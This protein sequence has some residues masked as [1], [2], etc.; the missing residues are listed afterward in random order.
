MQF[1]PLA[2][3]VA[4]WRVNACP[5]L[6]AFAQRRGARLCTGQCNI[7]STAAPCTPAVSRECRLRDVIEAIGP[8]LERGSDN[9]MFVHIDAAQEDQVEAQYWPRTF[10]EGVCL[11]YSF[12]DH[13]EHLWSRRKY[14]QV[15][16]VRKSVLAIAP[17]SVPCGKKRDLRTLV[18]YMKPRP[19]EHERDLFGAYL[20][21]ALMCRHN[22]EFSEDRAAS[23]VTQWTGYKP[24]GLVDFWDLRPTANVCVRWVNEGNTTWNAVS[25][26]DE[27]P[28]P[29]HEVTAYKE[30]IERAMRTRENPGGYDALSAVVLNPKTCL[31]DIEGF[32]DFVDPLGADTESGVSGDTPVAARSDAK[33]QLDD[34]GE[35]CRLAHECGRVWTRLNPFRRTRNLSVQKRGSDLRGHFVAV[36]TSDN[37]AHETT[38]DP[39]L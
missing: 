32:E 12:M 8:Q 14:W 16:R 31:R 23:L 38:R 3:N 22:R 1:E 18:M 5:F 4:R 36:P 19:T 17:V 7:M 26:Y 39:P 20:A 33:L 30:A 29:V 25:T 15:W 13:S 2:A 37:S 34:D 21:L 6:P 9:Y 27:R 11:M 35:R 10:F 28:F 24:V